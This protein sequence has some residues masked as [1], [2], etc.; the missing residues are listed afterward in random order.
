MLTRRQTMA[1][2]AAGTVML[3][4]D[5]TARTVDPRRR[6]TLW[7]RQPATE[8]TQA[9]PVGNGRL[10]A[11]VFGGTREDRLQLNEGTDRKSVV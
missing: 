5:G 3:S 11:M 4:M 10:G 9:L 8:W 7:Y 6:T 2:M 1:A